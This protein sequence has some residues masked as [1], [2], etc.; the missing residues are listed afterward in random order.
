VVDIMAEPQFKK[1]DYVMFY[2]FPDIYRK[3]SIVSSKY[4]K[5]VFCND[6]RYLVETGGG[7]IYNIKEC[8]LWRQ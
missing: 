3:G 7:R 2:S 8:N 1:G 4:C 6:W 5:G